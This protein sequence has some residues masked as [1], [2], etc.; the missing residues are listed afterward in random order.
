MKKRNKLDTRYRHPNDIAT[1]FPRPRPMLAPGVYGKI[2]VIVTQALYHGY[3]HTEICVSHMTGT[4]YPRYL[5]RR[6]NARHD[7]THWDDRAAGIKRLGMKLA[8]PYEANCQCD[9][10]DDCKVQALAE[11]AE[12]V[13][14]AWAEA[15]RLK[16]EWNKLGL[17]PG[18]AK[19]AYI[20][21][22]NEATKLNDELNRR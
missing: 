16:T 18:S 19:D 14:A 3:G 5:V 2:P 13:K 8:E 7:I 10:M 12:R 11:M 22:Y 20:E 6:R 17:M 15:E 4:L 1:K 9:V 21:A